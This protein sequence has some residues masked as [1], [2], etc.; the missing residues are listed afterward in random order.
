MGEG[1]AVPCSSGITSLAAHKL[2][3]CSRTLFYD[4][5]SLS[6]RWIEKVTYIGPAKMVS[7]NVQHRHDIEI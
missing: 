6:F 1:V 2:P 5:F 4:L 3:S 7:I